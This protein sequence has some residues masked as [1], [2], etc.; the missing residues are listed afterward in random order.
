MRLNVTKG[1][2]LQSYLIRSKVAE[3]GDSSHLSLTRQAFACVLYDLTIRGD[4]RV[5][6]TIIN[7]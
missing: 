3:V 2:T 1:Q 4:F 5:T 6:I 7:T